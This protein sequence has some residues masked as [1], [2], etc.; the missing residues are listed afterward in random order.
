MPLQD[1]HASHDINYED[2]VGTLCEELRISGKLQPIKVIY[3]AIKNQWMVID[4][5]HRLEA[6]K[7]SKLGTFDV[8]VIVLY[9]K[10][11]MRQELENYLR[12]AR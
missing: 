9:P 3:D 6:Y 1:L 10:N 8:P 12:R 5:N 7:C 4:G 2:W 11:A